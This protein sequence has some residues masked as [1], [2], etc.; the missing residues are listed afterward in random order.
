MRVMLAKTVLLTGVLAIAG[1][2][3]VPPPSGLTADP[4]ASLQV[5]AP[6]VLRR[7]VAGEPP[8]ATRDEFGILH[9]TLPL[10]NTTDRAFTID[11]KATFYDR[12]GN[13]LSETGWMPKPL[14]ANTPAT[15][16]VNSPSDR[17]ADF[18]IALRRAK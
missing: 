15:I 6:P 17:A 14:E 5:Y 7:Q 9:V 16:Q 18:A 12:E 1:C 11:Y 3:S 10:R 13:V 8:R 2:Q 4:D